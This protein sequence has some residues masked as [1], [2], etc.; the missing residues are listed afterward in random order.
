MPRSPPILRRFS[1]LVKE[2]LSAVSAFRR[3][4]GLLDIWIPHNTH[5]ECLFLCLILLRQ[6]LLV[7]IPTKRVSQLDFLGF[8]SMLEQLPVEHVD[9]M[10]HTFMHWS[11]GCPYHLP[12]KALII[13]GGSPQLAELERKVAFEEQ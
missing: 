6:S 13:A 7:V 8:A 2:F 4:L 3:S 11:L 9:R 1:G 10:A 12:F 5:Q